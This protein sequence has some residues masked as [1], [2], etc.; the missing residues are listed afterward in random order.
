M[1]ALPHRAELGELAADGQQGDAGIPQPERRQA[2]EL[3]AEVERQLG[4]ADDGVHAHDGRE[5]LLGEIL[6]RAGGECLGKCLDVLAADGET[7][8]S[9]VPAP[10]AEQAGARAECAVQVERRD[11]APGARPL[12]VAAR[13]EHD[14]AVEALDEPRR[15]DPDHPAVP[16]L[17]GEH[18]AAAALLRFRPLG[19]LGESLTQDPVL[20]RLAVAV[21]A[22]RARP[23]AGRLPSGRPS[24]E[25]RARCPDA[26]AVR[27][28]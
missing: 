20:D 23:R 26:R 11:R 14:R 7:G 25:A 6:G 1:L 27:R 19:N 24:G 21:E 5:I 17:A 16:V 2:L 22:S 28:R 8:G 10:A 9:P 15:D 13:D 18:V 3:R 4:A 12:L